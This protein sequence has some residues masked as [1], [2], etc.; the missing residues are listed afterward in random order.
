MSKQVT[1]NRFVISAKTVSRATS[2]LEKNERSKLTAVIVKLEPVN[3]GRCCLCGRRGMLPCCLEYFN[4]E[5]CLV[6]WG[7]VCEE[8]AAKTMEECLK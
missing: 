7:D 4:G 5:G 8:C 6:M 3:Y 2:K 1:L